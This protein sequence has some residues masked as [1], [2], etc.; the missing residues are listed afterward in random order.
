MDSAGSH[1]GARDWGGDLPYWG[2]GGLRAVLTSPR[3]KERGHAN[4]RD[5]PDPYDADEQITPAGV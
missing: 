4:D 2:T 3:E 1:T 5:Q